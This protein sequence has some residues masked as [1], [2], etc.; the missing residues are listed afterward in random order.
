VPA[1]D[2]P[3]E[4]LPGATERGSRADRSRQDAAPTKLI[5]RCSCCRELAWELLG[6]HAHRARGANQ[7]RAR[8]R[9]TICSE[10]RPPT[11]RPCGVSRRSGGGG[12]GGV[13]RSGVAGTMATPRRAGLAPGASR[14]Q[15]DRLGWIRPSLL[16]VC[17]SD[18]THSEQV[19]AYATTRNRSSSERR[20]RWEP[21]ALCRSLPSSS[22]NSCPCSSTRASLNPQGSTEQTNS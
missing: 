9:D 16:A 17:P 20:H 15:R 8:R 2:S 14:I 11:T 18:S 4:H 1:P 10:S 6:E 21:P 5:C 19:T 3:W 22:R 7:P 12:A 13:A